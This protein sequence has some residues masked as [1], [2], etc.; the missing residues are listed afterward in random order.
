MLFLNIVWVLYVIPIRISFEDEKYVSLKV[1]IIDI[2]V[3][4]LFLLDLLMKL[5]I[6][7]IVSKKGEF[8]YN[9]RK[10]AKERVFW[11]FM[12]FIVLSFLPM[13]LMKYTSGEGTQDDL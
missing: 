11:P 6:I 13:S 9:R 8:V 3:D 2:L 1:V 10:I 5:F 4:F 7:P 12:P